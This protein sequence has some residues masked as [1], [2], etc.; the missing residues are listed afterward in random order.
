M[1]RI[2]CLDIKVQKVKYI[3]ADTTGTIRIGCLIAS[4]FQKRKKYIHVYLHTKIGLIFDTIV[5]SQ[6]RACDCVKHFLAF[7]SNEIQH[8]NCEIRKDRYLNVRWTSSFLVWEI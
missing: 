1:L 3:D 6:V 8:V 2:L 4:T 5:S 7:L